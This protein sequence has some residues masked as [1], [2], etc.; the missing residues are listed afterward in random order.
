VVNGLTKP[1]P[2]G[3][4]VAD[5]VYNRNQNRVYLTNPDLDRLEVFDVNDTS[6]KAGIPVGSDPWG[7]A[8][9]PADTLGANLD[10]V[11]V[12]N[13]GGT[14]I[15]IVDV[16]LGREI[17]RHALPNFVI[18]SVQY[19]IDPQTS[20]LKLKVTSYDFSDRPQYL[21]ATCRPTT[22][23]TACAADSIYAVYGTA[24][25]AAQAADLADRG[26]VRW[27]NLTSATPQAHFFWEQAE[28]PPSPEYDTLEVIVDRGPTSTPDTIVSAACGIV[29]NLNEQAF[30][31]S[32]FV[33]N[34]GNFTHALFGEGGT[35]AKGAFDFA[36]AMAYNGTSTITSTPCTVTLSGITFSGRLERDRGISPG[37]R[38]SDFLVN[39]AIPIR[40][41]AVNFN[42]LTNMVR[43]DSVYVFDEALRLRGIIGAGG[44]NVGMDLNFDHTF[45]AGTGG[46]P[47]TSGGTL[48]PNA[49]LLFAASPD[50]EI[51]VFDTYFWGKVATIP[52]RIR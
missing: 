4:H 12:A 44:N 20:T 46:T 27:E 35:G 37:I 33:R 10:R 25:T 31:D 51:D 40:S 13:S 43:A 39:T 19:E 22:G 41:V 21:A 38:V 32:T 47:G 26:T 7:I 30:A 18:Q 17:A 50:P 36:R 15:S 1:L 16:G 23:G 14:D 48:D 24:G 28:K 11:M 42:G 29:V 45:R 5:A 9:W 52:S 3:G 6:F 2:A 34:S 49:R 8:L